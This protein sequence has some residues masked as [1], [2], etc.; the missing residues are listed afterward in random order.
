M[1]KPNRVVEPVI[2]WSGSKRLVAPDLSRLIA[3]D[4][5]RY[6]EP[7]LGGGAMLP[8][9]QIDTGIV[10]DIIPELIHLWQ[11]IQ[12]SPEQVA[13]EYSIR[14]ERLQ[15]EGHAVY[16]EVRDSFNATR[17]PFDFLFLTRTCVNGLIRYNEKG[18][19]NN[20]FHLTRP[21]INPK[22]LKEII[23]KWHYY[24]KN[25]SFFKMDYRETLSQANKHDF[26]FLDPPYGGT[27]GRY[28]KTEFDLNAFY[29]ELE[30]LNSIGAKWVLT[31]DGTAGERNYDY[32]LSKDLYLHKLFIKTGNSPFTKM[33]R[34]TIDEISESVYLNFQP[35]PEIITQFSKQHNQ[36]LSLAI[37]F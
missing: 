33:M 32:E 13:A 37:D 26:V 29:N 11:E 12:R 20:S 27:K 17:N 8:F 2:K 15:A 22:S 3:A 24:V 36:E 5:S 35:S 9:R 21:G 31:F 25:V 18:D 19:F 4:S 7:F 1:I 23:L 34:T 16:Y 28:T 6:I 14:W 10:S 30:R